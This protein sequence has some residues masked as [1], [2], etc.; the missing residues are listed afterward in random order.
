MWARVSRSQHPLV[1][2][3]NNLLQL[4]ERTHLH[5]IPLQ[6]SRERLIA[7]RLMIHP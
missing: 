3:C 2:Q 6:V 1:I 4:A 5:Q 7:T